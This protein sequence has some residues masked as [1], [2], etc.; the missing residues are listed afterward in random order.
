MNATSI[1]KR[2]GIQHTVGI[3]AQTATKAT[4]VV[5]IH[6]NLHALVIQSPWTAEF[7]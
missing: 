3:V 2:G 5:N 6:M 7:N 4:P 1:I